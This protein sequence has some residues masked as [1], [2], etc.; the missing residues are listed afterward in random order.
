MK[1]FRFVFPF[2][3]ERNWV[4]GEWELSVSRLTLFII[5]VVIVLVGVILA[6]LLQSPVEY[7]AV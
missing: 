4:T 5:I 2:L 6:V 1:F 3:F 7:T